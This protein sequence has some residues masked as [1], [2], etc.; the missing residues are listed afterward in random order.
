MSN[1]AET[2][3]IVI[4]GGSAGMAAAIQAAILGMKVT[5]FDASGID[6]DKPCG[7]G[8]MPP[9]VTALR[10]LGV[11]IPECFPFGGIKYFLHTGE[12]ASA[13]FPRGAK[14]IGVRRRLLRRA[15]WERA[16]SLGVKIIDDRAAT[17]G[18]SNDGV[19]VDG[20]CAK[21][22][23][24]ATGSRDPILKQLGLQDPRDRGNRP[25][26]LGLRR[27]AQI[28]PWSDSVEVYW[29]DDCELYVTPI[30]E[31]RVNIAILSWTSRSFE[32]ALK[33]FPAI[34]NRLIQ[35]EW[36]DP[37][38]GVAPL[39]HKADRVQKGRVFVAG[40]AAGFID[41]MTGEGNTLAI[42]SGMAVAESIARNQASKYRWLWISIV[43]RYWLVT[44]LAMT[45]NRYPLSRNIA[46]KA[47][48]RWPMLLR[49][50]VGILSA[51]I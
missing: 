40:D 26:R 27:H 31:S 13:R 50:G 24:L 33:L 43:W 44:T 36:D 28:A 41:A 16:M 10:Q 4:G 45:L 25:R 46:L 34:Q 49:V 6:Y 7:E 5:V 3:L 17:I 9:A 2:D 19:V 37:V 22:L 39:S 51:E 12:V 42:R 1:D 35:V 8:L 29:N 38:R 18:E 30:S 20:V 15:M 14:A 21:W 11:V 47:V 48:V 23:C 32:D